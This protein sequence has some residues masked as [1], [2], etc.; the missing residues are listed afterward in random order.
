MS[1][2]GCPAGVPASAGGN[3]IGSQGKREPTWWL[4]V[5]D[6]DTSILKGTL[7]FADRAQAWTEGTRFH[8]GD[9]NLADTW[10]TSKIGL[11][12]PD[13]KPPSTDSGDGTL[14]LGNRGHI[15]HKW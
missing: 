8:A 9:G 3:R 11:R 15:L 2:F 4:V 10:G 7:D 5:G 13:G 1:C 6:G 12:P 14:F